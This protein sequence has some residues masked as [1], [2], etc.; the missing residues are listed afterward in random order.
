[1]SNEILEQLSNLT[2]DNGVPIP[3]NGVGQ[4]NSEAAIAAEEI[5]KSMAVGQSIF[6]PVAQGKPQKLN[7]CRLLARIV[8]YGQKRLNMKFISR[9]VPGGMR[10][11]RTQ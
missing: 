7:Q 11:W 10:I 6:E 1:M 3:V 5:A 4:K 2:I 9:Q 8:Y